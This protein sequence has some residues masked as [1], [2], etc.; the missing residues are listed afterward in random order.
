[1]FEQIEQAARGALEHRNVVGHFAEQGNGAI[2]HAPRDQQGELAAF[3]RKAVE[4]LGLELAQLARQREGL[5]PKSARCGSFTGTYFK[6]SDA[7]CD[8]AASY[9]P[10]YSTFAERLCLS[11]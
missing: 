2:G 5:S 10:S 3:A 8:L 4:T 11:A 9:S 6:P 7:L 1:M